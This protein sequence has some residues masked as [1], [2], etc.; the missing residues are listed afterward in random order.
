MPRRPAAPARAAARDAILLGMSS[1]PAAALAPASQVR[2]AVALVALYIVWGSTYL[3]IRI[4]VETIPPLTGSAVRFLIAG[5]LLYLFTIRS[6]DAAADR[7]GRL[8]WR[9]AAIIGGLLPGRRERAPRDRRADRAVRDRRP[10][11][12]HPAALGRDPGPGLLRGRPDEDDRRRDR[13]RLRRRG[14]PR[15][16]FGSIGRPRPVRCAALPPLAGLLG[17]RL[18]LQSDRPRPAPPA[19]R[20]GH[21][22]ARGKR[23]ALRPGH[24]HGRHLP[25]ARRGDRPGV[26]G[27]HRLPDRH[28]LARRLHGLHAGSSASRR[29][30]WSRPTPSSTP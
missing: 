4:A 23:R 20:D 22:D 15:L 1:R 13:H 8:E 9:D 21:P 26:T 24:D 25:P 10:D 7:P 27:G 12:R 16:A 18:A 29:S 5:S 2:I 17:D 11:H 19:G 6:G 30:R 28:R 3:A 14:R